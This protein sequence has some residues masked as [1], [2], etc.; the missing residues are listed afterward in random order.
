MKSDAISCPPRG[1]SQGE[2]ILYVGVGSMLLMR[3]LRMGA[4]P[5]LSASML[6]AI[7]DLH[8]LDCRISVKIVGRQ[9]RYGHSAGSKSTCAI[10]SLRLNPGGGMRP[11]SSLLRA[12]RW[13]KMEPS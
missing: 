2:A 6:C 5:D 11:Q 1:L 8:Q 4:C 7:W 10:R 9:L 12:H 13:A 3:W